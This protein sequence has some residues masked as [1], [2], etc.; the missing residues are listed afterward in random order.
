MKF[1]DTNERVTP[2]LI[3]ARRERRGERVDTT[4]TKVCYPHLERL[5]ILFIYLLIYMVSLKPQH[6]YDAFC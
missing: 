6:D 2:P 5:N 3:L 4:A 1:A